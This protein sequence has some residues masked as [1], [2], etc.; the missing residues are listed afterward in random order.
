M[1][2]GRIGQV[3]LALFALLVL[4]GMVIYER[5]FNP[6]AL[7]GWTYRLTHRFFEM[8]HVGSSYPSREVAVQIKLGEPPRAETPEAAAQTCIRAFA[9]RSLQDGQTATCRVFQNRETYHQFKA[10]D[11]TCELARAVQT[12]YGRAEDAQIVVNRGGVCV[13]QKAS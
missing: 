2:L 1:R 13:G 7:Q 10:G 12:P 5:A 9:V 8:Q 11:E 3:V 4:T 6:N